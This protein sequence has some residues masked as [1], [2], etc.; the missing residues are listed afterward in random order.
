MRLRNNPQA[1]EILINSDYVIKQKESTYFNNKYPIHLEIGVGKG[2]FIIGMAKKYPYINFIGVE[3]YATVLVKAL[4]KLND[5]QL[6]NVLLLNCDASD[7]LDYFEEHTFST[8]YLNFSD[9]WPKK[10]HYKRRLTYHSFLSLYQKLLIPHGTIKQKTDN[11]LLFESSL[12]SYSEYG[13][14]FINL[15]LDLHHSHLN[16][17][18]VMSEYEQKFSKTQPIYMVEVKY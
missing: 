13:M 12:L 6:S 3:K 18:N 4:Q 16:K 2:D 15:T 1:E 10:R 17:D 14:K 9:P 5:E 8:L 7:L 11:A